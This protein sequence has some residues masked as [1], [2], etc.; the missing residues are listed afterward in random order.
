MDH[1][2]T[3]GAHIIGALI[4]RHPRRVDTH[5]HIIPE[6]YAQAVEATGG[7]PAGWP[8]PK[9]SPQLAKDNMSLLGVEMAITSVTAPGTKIY[10]GNIE[11]GRDFARKLNE[12][13]ANLV[14]NNPE[15]FG[16]FATLPSL[17]DIDGAIAEIDYVHSV[18]KPDGFILFTSYGHGKYLGHSSFRP[19]WTKLNDLNAIVFIH[20]SE[21]PTPIVNRHM[22]HPIVDYPHE[23]TRT[24][25]DIVL[26]GTRAAFPNVTIILSHAGGTLPFL[27][28]RIAGAGF[29]K[30]LG[31]SRGPLQIL[32]DLRSFYFDTALASSVIQLKALLEF[33][34]HSKI[35]FGSDVP[36]AT[37]PL[38]LYMT[39][40]LDTFFYQN[41]NTKKY[42][43]LWLN[44]NRNN[45]KTLFPQKIKN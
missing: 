3:Q 15:Q 18:L 32:S 14:K 6:F 10:E 36:Y 37:F 45:A 1:A 33:A 25:A 44:I 27:A 12:Y 4:N 20:P 19:I 42:K 16:F 11:K 29:I 7:D 40:C 30:S 31:C 21:A 26:S 8:I 38:S 9:W 34:D 22:P 39:K 23:T 13:S 28:Q 41:Y 5:H 2:R 17:T 35:L 43:D 24:A